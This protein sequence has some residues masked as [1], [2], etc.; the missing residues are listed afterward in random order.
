MA[1][2]GS[3]LL[4]R[5]AE[6]HRPRSEPYRPDGEESPGWVLMQCRACDGPVWKIR[7]PYDQTYECALW[8]EYRT[9]IVE[10]TGE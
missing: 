6:C 8:Q 2:G 1:T 4:H 3:E 5:L 7:A 9:R 10:A